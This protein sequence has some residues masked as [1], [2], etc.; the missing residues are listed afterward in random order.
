MKKMIFIFAIAFGVI[1]A[2]LISSAFHQNQQSSKH[3]D[4]YSHIRRD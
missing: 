3:I 1:S 4:P 2:F